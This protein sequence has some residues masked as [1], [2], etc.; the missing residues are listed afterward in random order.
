MKNRTGKECKRVNCVFYITYVNWAK[1]LGNPILE[2]CRN[3]KHAHA[4]QYKK[5]DGIFFIR[6]V[7]LT[8]KE[9]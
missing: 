5:G 9:E 6:E 1:N 4:S 7:S 3:C 8:N 2:N